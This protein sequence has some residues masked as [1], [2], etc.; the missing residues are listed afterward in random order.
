MKKYLPFL[1]ASMMAMFIYRGTVWLWLIVDVFQFFMMIFLWSSVYAQNAVINGFTFH[2]MLL[3][4][5]LT[6]VFYIFTE[7]ETHY[8]M[9]EEI[10]EG[11]ISLYFIKPISY[12]GRLY[13][14]ALGRA[15]SV[16][17][18]VLPIALVT[19][20]ITYGIFSFQLNVQWESVMLAL[21]F[22]PFIFTLMFEFTYFF[23]TL[24]IY[25]TNVFGLA[26]LISVFT[27]AVSGQLIPIALYP[28]VLR[29]V[30]ESM[31]FQYISYPVLLILGKIPLSS[32]LYGLGILVLWVGI[33]HLFNRV[34]SKKSMKKMVV[35]GG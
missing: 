15:L 35:F 24:T 28:T 26:I 14:E 11:R 12:K 27:R 17:V 30:I 32:G 18:L 2:E 10:K 1:K 22:I 5:L 9:S 23:G 31:P 34:L 8:I 25:T 13:S 20:L 19:F 21:L 6:N 33:F 29:N 3:Y 16:F 7:H 4:Y